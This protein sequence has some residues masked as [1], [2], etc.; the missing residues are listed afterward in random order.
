MRTGKSKACGA[1]V[2]AWWRRWCGLGDLRMGIE[3]GRP[4]PTTDE[5]L[6]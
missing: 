1:L 6:G 5:V 3:I 2:A 4:D